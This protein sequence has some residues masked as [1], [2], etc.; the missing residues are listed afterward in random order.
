MGD[1]RAA[2]QKGHPFRVF[3]SYSHED[4]RS[5]DTVVATLQGMG[6]EP[7]WDKNI[8]P[9]MPFTDEIKGLI[10][11]AHLF[12]PLITKHSRERPWVHQETGYAMALN[13]PVLPLA[14]GRF[15]GEMIAQLQAVK[16]RADL[17]DLAAQLRAVNIERIV[18]PLSSRLPKISEVADVPERRTELLAQCAR[19]VEELGFYGQLRQRGALSSFCI[20][21][22][23]VNSRVWNQREG[24]TRR[25]PYYRQLQREERQALERHARNQGCSLII[26]PTMNL[27]KRGRGITH[28]RLS[29][30]LEFLDSMPDDKVAV[31]PTPRARDGSLTIVGDWFIAESLVPGPGGY[32]QTVFDWHAPTA[33]SWVRRFDQEFRELAATAP[34]RPRSGQ[35]ALNE[36][37]KIMRNLPRPK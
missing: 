20:P 29:T 11:H 32:R 4:Q 16:V 9:G 5:A 23:D 1:K 35:Q 36:I 30:L 19:R 17:R 10:T 28:T 22:C 2:I 3:V 15:P 14:V 31:T 37:R 34:K 8:R 6:L 7:L 27:D 26:D 24:T 18:S 21:D 13:I 25:T 12:V 33:L